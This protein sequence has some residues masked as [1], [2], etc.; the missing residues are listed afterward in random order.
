MLQPD[1]CMWYRMGLYIQDNEGIPKTILTTFG[2]HESMI[3][4]LKKEVVQQI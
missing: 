3:T 2:T 4:S 1:Y